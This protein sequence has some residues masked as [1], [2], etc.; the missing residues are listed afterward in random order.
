MRTPSVFIGEWYY[1]EVHYHM[2]LI[3]LL[4]YLICW[5]NIS[6]YFGLAYLFWESFFRPYTWFITMYIFLILPVK[7]R[8][9]F[10]FLTWTDLFP[11]FC[12]FKKARIMAEDNTSTYGAVASTQPINEDEQETRVRS[13][14]SFYE[15]QQRG[16]GD[17]RTLPGADDEK[18][19]LN[20][21]QEEEKEENPS[22]ESCLST[23]N[24]HNQHNNNDI[25]SAGKL[26]RPTRVSFSDEHS[27]SP[28]HGAV[29]PSGRHVSFLAETNQ[30]ES[31][32]PS[33]AYDNMQSS[34]DS[35]SRVRT[36]T[37]CSVHYRTHSEAEECNESELSCALS[38]HRS[39]PQIRRRRRY[40]NRGTMVSDSFVNECICC[41]V[42]I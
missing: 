36:I 33:V 39:N 21:K 23:S 11:F 30:N 42:I 24:P 20:G 35:L 14:D 27:T 32:D 41:C 34:S 10:T 7:R 15:D 28:S 22:D 13:V 19:E 5:T 8:Q 25:R 16:T 29:T 1:V 4:S 18:R 37:N 40:T 17:Q 26:Q 38:Y 6:T 3:R 12:S 31:S 2:V 9:F